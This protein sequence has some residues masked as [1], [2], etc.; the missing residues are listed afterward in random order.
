MLTEIFCVADDFCKEF[1]KEFSKKTIDKQ[2]R[3]RK[4]RP[5]R[6]S[7]S[8]I[9][10]I[11]I[12][13]HHSK[14]RTFKDYYEILI[15]V[16]NKSAFNGLVSYSRFVRLAQREVLTLFIF[17]SSLCPKSSTGIHYIDSAPLKV[18]H[19]KRIPGNKTFK[20]VAKRGK[21]SVGWFFGFKLHFVIN[22][23]GEIVNFTITPGNISD[24]NTKV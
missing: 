3:A 14:F 1:E 21:S 2:G 18:C 23:H 5:C 12:F 13:F 6:L 19:N 9:I 20:D 7:R 17:S 24:Q 4:A 8:E 16:W 11:L 22:A 10:T 15:L